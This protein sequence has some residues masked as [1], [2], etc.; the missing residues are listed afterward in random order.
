[1]PLDDTP[2]ATAPTVDASETFGLQV[3]PAERGEAI[4]RHLDSQ[5][6]PIQLLPEG[7]GSS[8]SEAGAGP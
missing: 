4:R 7:P 5:S 3:S 2:E 8:E 6:P 1:M